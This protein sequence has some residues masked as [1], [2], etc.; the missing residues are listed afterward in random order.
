MTLFVLRADV[1][2]VGSA[3]L[4]IDGVNIGRAFPSS[5]ASSAAYVVDRRV[6]VFAGRAAVFVATTYD[7]LDCRVRH[8]SGDVQL[9]RTE[10]IAPYDVTDLMKFTANVINICK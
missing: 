4:Q 3:N 8:S 5:V 2:F 6:L 10:A 1:P 9:T 7:A